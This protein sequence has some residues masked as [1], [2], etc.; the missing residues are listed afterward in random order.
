MP[1]ILPHY[2]LWQDCRP[3][4]DMSLDEGLMTLARIKELDLFP[5]VGQFD[6][7]PMSPIPS[8]ETD[9]QQEFPRF[10]ANLWDEVRLC[11]IV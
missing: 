1:N 10:L 2:W 5:V 9:N 6:T 4:T 11:L 3:R 8:G 7:L